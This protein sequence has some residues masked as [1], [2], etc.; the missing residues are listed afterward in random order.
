MKFEVKSLGNQEPRCVKEVKLEILF[1]HVPFT[2]IGLRLLS[3]LFIIS[4]EI[5]GYVSK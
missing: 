5:Q 1:P 4:R 2:T 3:G